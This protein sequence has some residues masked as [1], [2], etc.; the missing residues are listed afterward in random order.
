MVAKGAPGSN[1]CVFFVQRSWKGGYTGFTLSVCPSVHLSVCP[2]MD[3]IVSAL[4]LQQYSYLRI[5]SSIFRRCVACKYFFKIQKCEI[6]ANSLNLKLWLCLLLTWDPTWINSMSN[7]VAAGV[8]SER[9]R[10]SCSSWVYSCCNCSVMFARSTW[11]RGL[12][13]MFS[14][15]TVWFFLHFTDKLYQQHTVLL[16]SYFAKIVRDPIW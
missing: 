11:R 12:N 14:Y 3:R 15:D 2:S 16:W 1:M 10:S 8:T 13:H 4:Y 6:L 5:L 7:H 9:R